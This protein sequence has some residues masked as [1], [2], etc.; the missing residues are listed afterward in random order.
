[1]LFLY[2][3]NAAS[4]PGRAGQRGDQA[5]VGAGDDELHPGRATRGQRPQERQPAGAVLLRAH[6]QAQDFTMPVGGDSANLVQAN[7]R[8]QERDIGDVVVLDSEEHLEAVLTDRMQ[9]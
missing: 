1:M 4:L 9:R 6:V 7:E 2:S 3:F 8:M 5:S